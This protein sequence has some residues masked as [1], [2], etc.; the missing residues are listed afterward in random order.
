MIKN[1]A[2]HEIEDLFEFPPPTTTR[3]LA[4]L[5]VFFSLA[6]PPLLDPFDPIDA[7]SRLLRIVK[8]I[9]ISNHLLKKV[10]NKLKINNAL[11]QTTIQ[12]LHKRKIKMTNMNSLMNELNE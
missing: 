9:L 10:K 5:L 4:S 3:T 12:N 8:Q 7:V 2:S 1:K 11:F 6:A